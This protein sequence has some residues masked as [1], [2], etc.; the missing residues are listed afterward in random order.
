MGLEPSANRGVENGSYVSSPPGSLNQ[1]R[2]YRWSC[3]RTGLMFP[4]PARFAVDGGALVR[5]STYCNDVDTG[6]QSAFGQAL[7]TAI[8]VNFTT[9]GV[10]AFDLSGKWKMTLSNATVGKINVNV[11]VLQATGGKFTGVVLDNFDEGNVGAD[12]ITG[13]VSGTT[14]QLD[15]SYVD[16]LFGKFSVKYGFAST[17]ED[18]DKDGFAYK[19]AGAFD[20]KFGNQV[21]PI[22]VTWKRLALPKDTK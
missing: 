22:V 12:A 4:M 13:V 18:T 17:M 11:A 6:L 15:P 2:A 3:P 10:P 21:F 5:D 14:A 16:S 8:T 19:G 1:A 9:G 20:F 7:P